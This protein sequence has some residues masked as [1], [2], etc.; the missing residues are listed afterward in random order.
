MPD[1]GSFCDKKKQGEEWG[2]LLK[3]RG[4]KNRMSFSM[5]NQLYYKIVKPGRMVPFSD[6]PWS[7]TGL[8][9]AHKHEEYASLW[10]EL[11]TE[12]GKGSSQAGKL[13]IIMPIYDMRLLLGQPHS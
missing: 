3:T 6:P 8:E 5:I 1:P 11:W 2:K 13:L 12:L 10:T 7:N 9:V 4:S